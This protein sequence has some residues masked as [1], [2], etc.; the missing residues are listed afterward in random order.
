MPALYSVFVRYEKNYEDGDDNYTCYNSYYDNPVLIEAYI[1]SFGS[2]SAAEQVADQIKLP[3]YSV[4]EWNEDIWTNFAFVYEHRLGAP[5][6]KDAVSN[7]ANDISKHKYDMWK[8]SP[9]G[10]AH[11]AAVERRAQKME[12][13]RLASIEAAK[14]R[15]RVKARAARAA[16]KE[17]LVAASS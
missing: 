1:G 10:V 16:K 17:A 5:V 4:P 11:T 8:I 14:E 3:D 13:N 9:A 2:R 12:A 15:V 6:E 7:K